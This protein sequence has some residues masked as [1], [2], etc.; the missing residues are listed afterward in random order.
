MLSMTSH[1][2][3]QFLFFLAVGVIAVPLLLPTAS[4]EQSACAVTTGAGNV[5]GGAGSAMSREE[6]IE[7]MLAALAR[8][9]RDAMRRLAALAVTLAQAM[10]PMARRL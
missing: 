9:D 10:V 8:A 7:L 3:R 4:A 6:L 1:S 2:G 5:E